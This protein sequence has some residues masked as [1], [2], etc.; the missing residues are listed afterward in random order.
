MTPPPLDEYQRITA[1]KAKGFHQLRRTA[2]NTA[3]YVNVCREVGSELKVPVVDIW[4]LFLRHAGW[5]EGEPLLGT[6]GIAANG[7][8]Q[9]FFSDG[10]C[11][12]TT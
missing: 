1:D 9:S 11:L 7:V 12:K 2:A 8:F 5:V 10:E 4:T 3:E 6:R